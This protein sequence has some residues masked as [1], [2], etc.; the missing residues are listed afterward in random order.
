MHKRVNMFVI[1]FYGDV[2]TLKFGKETLDFNKYAVCIF[3]Y[4]F[5]LQ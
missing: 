1:L 2:A 5:C 4:I 3:L